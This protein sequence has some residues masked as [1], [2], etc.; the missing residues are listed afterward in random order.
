M[1]S[2]SA[3]YFDE[4]SPSHCLPLARDHTNARLQLRRLQQGNATGEIAL[5]GLFCTAATRSR[6][7]LLRV[8]SRHYRAATAIA[9]LPRSAGIRRDAC[10]CSGLRTKRPAASRRCR[11]TPDVNVPSGPKRGYAFITASTRSGN[12]GE[13]LTRAPVSAATALLRAGPTNGVAICPTPVG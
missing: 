13:C 9:G 12:N 1:R 7:Y 8:I 5:D 11:R 2:R 6:A 4:I 3:V 10:S